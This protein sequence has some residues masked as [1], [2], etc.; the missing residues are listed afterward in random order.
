MKINYR[1]N[2]ICIIL[3]VVLHVQVWTF[4][5]WFTSMTS[6]NKYILDLRSIHSTIHYILTKTSH[7]MF[8]TPQNGMSKK[9]NTWATLIF[10]SKLFSTPLIFVMYFFRNCWTQFNVYFIRWIFHHSNFAQHVHHW[11][12]KHS[13]YDGLDDKAFFH[14]QKVPKVYLYLIWDCVYIWNI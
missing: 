2:L 3:F 1:L 8:P 11:G 14:T 5:T 12:C 6:R 4:Q 13:S 7:R 9:L 10:W